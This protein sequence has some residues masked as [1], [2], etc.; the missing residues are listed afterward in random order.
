MFHLKF[1]PVRRVKQ[2]AEV[3]GLCAGIAYAVGVHVQVIQCLMLAAIFFQ[4]AA[5]VLY[6]VFGM[7]LPKWQTLPADYAAVVHKAR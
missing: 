2:E 3:L 4:P 1:R 5:L 6:V 7:L